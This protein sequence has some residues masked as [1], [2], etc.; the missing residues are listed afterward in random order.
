M[1]ILPSIN[2]V[3]HR[4]IGSEVLNYQ[5]TNSAAFSGHPSEREF[6]GHR[7]IK[8]MFGLSRAGLY[9]YQALGLIKSASVRTPGAIRGRRLWF[10]PSIR[11]LLER[12]LTTTGVAK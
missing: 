4:E 1:K 5:S 11:A 10:V 3:A 12:N 7:E 2:T 6:A 9:R 8:Q